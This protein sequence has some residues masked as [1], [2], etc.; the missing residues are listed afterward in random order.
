MADTQ[1]RWELIRDVLVFQLKLVLDAVRDFALSPL[2]IGAA[3]IDLFSGDEPP[4]RRF[5]AVLRAGQRAERW[6][7]LYRPAG[8][9]EGAEELP[10][11]DSVVARVE[12]LLAQQVERGGVTAQAKAV[13][14]RSLDAL[15]RRRAG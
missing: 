2:S 8:E 1:G 15:T 7:D 13:I 6:L 12:A 11:V 14:D 5:Y 3:L 4:G 9:L 10:G